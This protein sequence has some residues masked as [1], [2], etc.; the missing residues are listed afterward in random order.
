MKTACSRRRQMAALGVLCIAALLATG[1]AYQLAWPGAAATV[2]GYCA[3]VLTALFYLVCPQP[4]PARWR[5]LAAVPLALLG[6]VFIFCGE[7]FSPI[8]EAAHFYTA[9]YIAQTGTLPNMIELP[10]Y[11]E[12]VQT[13]LYYLFASFFLRLV[14]SRTGQ[15]FVLRAVNF[16]LLWGCAHLA[17]ASAERLRQAGVPVP[18][19]AMRACVLFFF[20]NPGVMVRFCTVS[21]EPLAVFFSACA[22]YAMVGLLCSGYSTRLWLICTLGICGAVL[23]KISALFLLAPA[24]CVLIWLRRPGRFAGCAG[25]LLLALA[26]WFAYNQYIY[27]AWTANAWHRAYVLPLIAPIRPFA[28]VVGA[29]FSTL[30]FPSEGRVGGWMAPLLTG[31]NF[32]ALAAAAALIVWA[33]ACA[34][35]C[36]APRRWF[37]RSPAVL[38]RLL[39]VLCAGFLV[40][41]LCVILVGTFTSDIDLL[42]GRYMM[43]TLGCM[44]LCCAHV[45]GRISHAAVRAATICLLVFLPVL[46]CVNTAQQ[47]FLSWTLR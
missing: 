7:L 25:I 33:C 27:G 16:L 12:S 11:Y 3:S 20:F 1:A 46:F 23:S 13:P 28:E 44:A 37:D 42:F 15:V 18:E 30:F 22:L 40:G 41:N 36:L 47:F 31:L 5:L 45:L 43:Y 14:P 8:D 21:N 2:L 32:A 34:A 6:A 29:F 38:S 9:N 24:L 39:Y 17:L 26:P 19:T 10:D 35:Y 4:L